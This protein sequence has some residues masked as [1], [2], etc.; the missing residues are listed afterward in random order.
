[1]KI[2]ISSDERRFACDALEAMQD[3]VSR[4]W[5]PDPARHYERMAMEIRNNSDDSHDLTTDDASRLLFAISS[6]KAFGRTRDELVGRLRKSFGFPRH[7]LSLQDLIGL[8]GKPAYLLS[9]GEWV[10]VRLDHQSRQHDPLPML[11]GVNFEYDP[12]ARGCLC[13]KRDPYAE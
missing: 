3:L 1:M 10:L 13:V 8:A 7:T 12:V 11:R 4:P 5:N 6:F 2:A 9:V